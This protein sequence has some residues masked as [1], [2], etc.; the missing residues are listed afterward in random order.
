MGQAC[1]PPGF[2][3]PPVTAGPPRKRRFFW[4]SYNRRMPHDL[5]L[6]FE[7][8]IER[9]AAHLGR[10][11]E[12]D[13]AKRPAQ[14]AWS[15]KQE[16][17]HL[18]D[19]AANNHVR[20]V[21]GSLQPEFRGPTYDGRGWVERHGYDHMPWAEILDFWHRYNRFVAALVRR[22]PEDRMNASCVI[23]DGRP[24]TLQF[25]IEDYLAHMQHHLDHILQRENIT[26]YPGAA[27]GI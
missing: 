21:F 19:S 24:V 26:Q 27:M 7:E 20:F 6:R 11:T 15:K 17:G 18:V 22:I 10:I 5:A 8:T 23:G 3:A 12:A 2:T 9:E 14:D 25:I 1:S 13:A 16:L 4:L